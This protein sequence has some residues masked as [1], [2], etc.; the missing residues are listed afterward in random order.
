MF[1]K[2]LWKM[3][4]HEEQTRKRSKSVEVE[5]ILDSLTDAIDCLPSKKEPIFEPHFKFVSIVHK[6]VK[7]GLLHVSAQR[8]GLA[9]DLLTACKAQGSQ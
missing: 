2:C 1:S 5:D 6:L 4:N 7:R 9:I 8:L 3:F